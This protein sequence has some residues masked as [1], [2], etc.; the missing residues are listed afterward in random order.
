MSLPTINTLRKFR[1][2]F[3]APNFIT[4]E[5][6]SLFPQVV[7][8]IVYFYEPNAGQ[9]ATTNGKLR[10]AIPSRFVATIEEVEL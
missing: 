5:I 1:I 8:D 3:Y 10:L 6:E 4:T 7:N 2:G 9:G